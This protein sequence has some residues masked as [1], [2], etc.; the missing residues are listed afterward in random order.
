MKVSTS[1]LLGFFLFFFSYSCQAWARYK[2]IVKEVPYTRLCSTKNI[3]TVNG[4]FPE[5]T[6]YVHKG[7]TIIVD[8]YKRGKHNI[9]IH[10]H[11]ARQPRN[12]W[13]DG[14]EYITQCAIQP[15][16]RFSQKIIFTTEEGTLW[17][18]AHSEW[19]R[20]T[21]HGAVVIYPKLGTSYPFPKPEAEMPIILG[22]WW[23][24][25]IMKIYEGFL[26][27]GGDP[28]VS[29]AYVVP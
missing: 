10:W 29:D 22:E 3:L 25:D 4:Q 18:H 15:G 1:Q 28:N 19:S 21:V 12:P 9:T 13:S 20:A 17:W 23:K 14:P 7:D 27:S 26:H 16:A 24:Q 6:L 5:P 8:V 11:G 2:F